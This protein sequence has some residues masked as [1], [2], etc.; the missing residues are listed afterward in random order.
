MARKCNLVTSHGRLAVAVALAAAGMALGAARAHAAVTYAIQFGPSGTPAYDVPAA[1]SDT[2]LFA[3]ATNITPTAAVSGTKPATYQLSNTGGSFENKTTGTQVQSYALGG[4]T[5]AFTTDYGLYNVGG[6]GASSDVATLNGAFFYSGASSN[7]SEV[8]LQL[9]GV[10]ATDNVDFKFIGSKQNFGTIVTVVGG[11]AGS[12]GTSTT[13]PDGGATSFTDA[14]T[15]SGATLYQLNF[16]TSGSAGAEGDV[17]GALVTISSPVSAV[18]A[19]ASLTVG[20]LGLGLLGAGAA[21][22]RRGFRGWLRP[23]PGY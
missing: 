16:T 7:V 20:L 6:Q 4:A 5:L 9:S 17:S 22:K 12:S 19:P 23:A 13:I 14:G 2:T 18:P 1:S 21:A 15:Y 3:G 10:A 11:T 8:T